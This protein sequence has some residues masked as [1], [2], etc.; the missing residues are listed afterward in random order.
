MYGVQITNEV[1]YI[2]VDAHG[3]HYEKNG[4]LEVETFDHLVVCAG[5]LSNNE[6][7]TQLPNAHVIGGAANAGELDA[8]RAIEEG[9]RVAMRL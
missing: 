9:T 8:K 3:L 5:Q 4:Q 7:T 1:K 2:K 6:F